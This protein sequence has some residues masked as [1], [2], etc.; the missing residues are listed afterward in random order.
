MHFLQ[1]KTFFVFLSEIFATNMAKNDYKLK[2]HSNSFD[3]L[4][5]FITSPTNGPG[6]TASGK[7]ITTCGLNR[8]EQTSR[9]RRGQSLNTSFCLQ[10]FFPWP[11]FTKLFPLFEHCLLPSERLNVTPPEPVITL[12]FPF[13]LFNT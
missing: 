6:T 1:L 4:F 11:A 12:R 7:P 13:Q 9:H 3:S 10:S 5:Q 8:K 2:Q